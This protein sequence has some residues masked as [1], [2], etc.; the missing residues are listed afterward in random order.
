[1]ILQGI[2]AFCDFITRDAQKG[3]FGPILGFHTKNIP[4]GCFDAYEV[5]VNKDIF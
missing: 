5:E 1:M 2:P 3:D 4:N